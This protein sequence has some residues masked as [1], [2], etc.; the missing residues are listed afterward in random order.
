MDNRREFLKKT[1][2]LSGAAGLSSFLPASIQRAFAINPEPG[3]TWT[4]AEHIVVLM[5]ENRSFDHCFGSLQGVRGF[6]DPR[7]VKLPNGNP[8]WLQTNA[9]G[10]TYA[11]FRLDIK[12]TKVT[13]MGDLPH[14]RASQVDANNLG[15]YDQWLEAKRSGNKKYADWPLTLGYYTREDL[16]FNYALADAFTVC[17]QH[18]CS[19]M[20]STWPNRLYFWSGTVRQQ[21][22]SDSIAFMRNDLPYGKGH[23]KTFP[24]RLEE[25]GVSWK[26]YQNEITAGGGFKG[27]ERSWLGNFGCNPL[28]LFSAYNVRYSPGYVKSLQNQAETLPLE[29]KAIE[30]KLVNVNADSKKHKKLS[31]DLTKKKE[32]LANAQAGLKQWTKENYE[33][34]TQSEKNL[35]ERAFS[36]NDEDPHYHEITTLKY[37]DGGTER[38]VTVPKGDILYRFRK[39]VDNGTLPTV[40]WIVGPQNFSDHPSAPWYGALYVSEILDILTKNPEVW[41]KT[42]FILTYDENDGYFDHV[43]PFMPPDPRDPLTGKTSK[44]INTEMEF[45]RLENELRDCIPEK[46]ARGGA[47]GL[48]YRVPLVIASPWSRGGKVCSEIFD[49][50]S[51]IQFME[52]FMKKKFNV[53]VTDDNVSKWR[54]SICGN[55]TSVFREYNGEKMEKLPF[56]EKDQFIEDIHKAQF[57]PEPSSFG[58]NMPKQEK[59]TRISCALP[60][61][62][63]ADGKLNNDKKN[64]EITFKAGNKVFGSKSMGSPFRVQATA[65]NPRYYAVEAGDS[66]TDTWS[67]ESFDDKK[68]HFQLHGPNGFYREFKG[69]TSDP[70]VQVS[71]NYEADGNINLVINN[72]GDKQYAINVE[73]RYTKK[74]IS[75]KIAANSSEP[76]NIDTAKNHGWYDVHLSIDGINEFSQHY[77]GRVETGKDSYT[78]PAMGN[79]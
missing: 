5:Q 65:G 17:D 33:A 68:Y 56:L 21:N 57:R 29:I 31:A 20:T 79:I 54:R 19:A 77:A 43:P 63:Y 66:V 15:K 18:F 39:D 9:K 49:H 53:D 13:W 26:V 45:I 12:D 1:A 35:H 32:V 61:E 2:L 38:E 58:Q 40:S 23:W 55:L 27:E 52:E 7:A 73:N 59:G 48:G 42:I 10:K 70:G 16:P 34:L 75:I 3:S 36:K 76:L 60:Y 74:S 4:D 30:E 22:V 37:N 8:V 44:G 69:D 24:E 72:K 47:I 71:C 78:D 46:D 41:K 28:E 51:A 50:T 14:S 64:F 6:N 62:L 25:K 11:P 67:I